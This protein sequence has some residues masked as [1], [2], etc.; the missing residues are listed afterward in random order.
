MRECGE[1]GTSVHCWWKCRLLWPLKHSMGLPQKSKNG[2]A[3]RPSNST[4]VNISKETQNT[5]L[6]EYTN[7]CVYC[8]AVY[9]S[10]DLEAAKC[11]SVDEWIKKL[12]YLF[13]MEY[14]TVLKKK[15]NL[16]FCDSMDGP[17]EHYGK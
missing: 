11:P 16:T 8:S 7:P 12:R 10:Q 6:K 15:G 17:R 2:N 14:Y 9:N 13:T 1:E 4:S 5:N 3:L